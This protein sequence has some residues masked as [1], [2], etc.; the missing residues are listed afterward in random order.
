MTSIEGKTR[1]IILVRLSRNKKEVVNVLI[2][3]PSAMREKVRRVEEIE[4]HRAEDDL[5]QWQWA[6][7]YYILY[8]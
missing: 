1:D 3:D 6:I 2:C 4:P 7:G 5:L 8:I